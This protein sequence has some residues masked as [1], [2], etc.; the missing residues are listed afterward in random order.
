M[1]RRST[2]ALL[3]SAVALLLLARLFTT[4][5]PG[6]PSLPYRLLAVSCPVTTTPIIAHI[7]QILSGL[8]VLAATLLVAWRLAGQRRW[9]WLAIILLIPVLGIVSFALIG[10]DPE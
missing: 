2:L 9:G 3:A 6:C 10:P 4:T 1:E 8:I 5:G 7:L